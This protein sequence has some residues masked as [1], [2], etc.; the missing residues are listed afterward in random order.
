MSVVR[1]RPKND[2]FAYFRCWLIGQGRLVYERAMADP[3]SLGEIFTGHE[4]YD[5][6]A[7][8]EDLLYVAANAHENLVGTLMPLQQFSG[9]LEPQGD[10]WKHEELD[11]LFPRLSAKFI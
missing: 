9:S 11:A 1:E 8:C 5:W 3:D 6:Y 2:G 4:G 10:R 7:E